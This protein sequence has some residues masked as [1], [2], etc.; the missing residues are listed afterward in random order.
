MKRKR[1]NLTNSGVKSLSPNQLLR[2]S[3][4]LVMVVFKKRQGWGWGW[5]GRR[6]GGR[7]RRGRKQ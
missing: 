6:K 1:C 3:K 2:Y 4:T 5:G 7:E